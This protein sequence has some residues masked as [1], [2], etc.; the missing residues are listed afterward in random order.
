MEDCVGMDSQEETDHSAP[1]LS[2]SRPDERDSI[3]LVRSSRA[4]VREERRWRNS[5][6]LGDTLVGTERNHQNVA[7]SQPNVGN[8][9]QR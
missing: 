6:A 1:C 7:S 3:D 8:S 4:S 9:R 2:V 5:F